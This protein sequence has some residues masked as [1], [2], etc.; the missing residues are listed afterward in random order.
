MAV[1]LEEG[2]S[3]TAMDKTSKE[4]FLMNKK[5]LAVAVAGALAAPGI[6]LAQ[7]A[8]VQLYGVIDAGF[9]SNHYSGNALG[10]GNAGGVG[11]VRKYDVFNGAPSRWGLRG[12]EDLGR[13]LKAWFQLEATVFNDGRQE[14]ATSHSGLLGGRN[15]AVGLE[16][17]WGNV[18]MG[19]WDTPYK[20]VGLATWVRGGGGPMYHG[21]MIMNNGDS[22]G[23]AP[24]AQCATAISP[25]TGALNVATPICPN[26]VEGNG[27]AF[28]RRFAN[29]IQYWS[30][31]WA[32]FQLKVATQVNEGKAAANTA[33]TTDNNPNP[34]AWS[35]GLTWA[36]GPW[37]AGLGYEQHKGFNTTS[38]SADPNVKDTGITLGGG[39]NFG[40][41]TVA[42]GWERLKYG[43]NLS[44]AAALAAGGGNGFQRTNWVINGTFNIGANGSIFAGYSKTPGGKSCGVGATTAVGGAVC[45]SNSAAS[46]ASLGYS[47]KLSKR[48]TLYAVAG[49]IN[50]SAGTAYYYIA[51]PNGPNG[52]SS[53]VSAGTDVTTFGVGMNHTF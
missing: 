30:P 8:N 11:S 5:L 50:N 53:I 52:I 21:G 19:L 31:N 7:A 4:N 28:H 6:A 2:V 1:R 26:Q 32:G 25:A 3:R 39:W 24:N 49:R 29:I 23:A 44:A 20:Q 35:Y 43:D 37:N 45:G 34:S 42:L 41:G 17:S 36:G 15:S 51:A 40:M 46:F 48:S 38:V 16:G 13:G 22:S 14:T 10:L 33:G 9:L 47:H 12:T 27:T 18:S